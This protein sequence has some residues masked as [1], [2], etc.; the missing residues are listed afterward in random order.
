[1]HILDIQPPQGPNAGGAFERLRTSVHHH[2]QRTIEMKAAQPQAHIQL[3]VGIDVQVA[4]AEMIADE[5]ETTTPSTP[6]DAE[7]RKRQLAEARDIE[8][9]H[10]ELLTAL[11]D[12]C[13]ATCQAPGLGRTL[14]RQRP[15]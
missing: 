2:A 13:G 6:A 10:C 11:Q 5:L 4:R 12:A 3:R 15:Q 8:R 14:P 7:V 1:M 9:A